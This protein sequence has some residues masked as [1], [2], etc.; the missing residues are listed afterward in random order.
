MNLDD[1]F[2]KGTKTG[3][4]LSLFVF[5]FFSVFIELKMLIFI[6]ALITFFLGESLI[7]LFYKNEKNKQTENN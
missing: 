1:D 3:I 2:N 7:P 4:Y 5:L 6:S